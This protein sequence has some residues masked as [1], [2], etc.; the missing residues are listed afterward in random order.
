MSSC[1]RLIH[2]A[3]KR[4]MTCKRRLTP[5]KPRIN[6]RTTSHVDQRFA[7][8]K[9]FLVASRACKL[10]PQF[11]AIVSWG[12]RQKTEVLLARRFAEGKLCDPTIVAPWDRT[13]RCSIL[14]H[15]LHF[16][17]AKKYRRVAAASSPAGDRSR[18]SGPSGGF[19]V[20]AEE[21]I[22]CWGEPDGPGPLRWPL[23]SAGPYWGAK[24]SSLSRLTRRG[25]VTRVQSM[26]LQ[27]LC[28]IN[29]KTSDL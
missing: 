9:S 16:A 21:S 1:K 20:V 29:G 14:Q 23:L 11:F 26:I 24:T 6:Q 5:T 3:R 2:A 7:I 8:D 19:L 27:S 4:S 17:V 13:I 28:Q 10:L 25:Q 12:K 18:C 15:V 22:A